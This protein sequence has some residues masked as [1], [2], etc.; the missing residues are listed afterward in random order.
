MR[1]VRVSF[2]VP[3]VMR[4]VQSLLSRKAFTGETTAHV[5][6]LASIDSAAPS[7]ALER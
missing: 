3:Q 1:S 4:K 5:I 7:L 2:S 6:D